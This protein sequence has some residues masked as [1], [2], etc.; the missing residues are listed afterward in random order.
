MKSLGR[1]ASEGSSCHLQWGDAYREFHLAAWT[2]ACRVLKP[3]GYFLLNIKDHVRNKE[4][5]GVP[6][7]HFETLQH[8]GVVEVRREFI[9]TPGQRRGEN[10]EARVLGEFLW[11]GQL[12]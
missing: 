2:E 7:W 6:F 8:L 4:T 1:E 9:A 3:G 10:H 5:Q 12:R 11:L